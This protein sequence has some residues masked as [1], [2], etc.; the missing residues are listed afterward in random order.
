MNKTCEGLTSRQIKLADGR[1]LIFYD[2]VTAPMPIA[3]QPGHAKMQPEAE[4]PI[5][6][7]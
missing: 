2:L 4:P 1:Y 6:D 5:E 3:S 7:N